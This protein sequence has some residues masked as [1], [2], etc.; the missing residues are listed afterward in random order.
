MRLMAAACVAAGSRRLAA[1][2]T[3][4]APGSRRSASALGVWLIIGALSETAFRVKASPHPGRE[5][6]RRLSNL[7]RSSFG[8]MMAHLGLGVL[9]IGIVATSAW[10]QERIL[11]MKAGETIN[12]AGYQLRFNDLASRP[13]PN[14][15]EL[16]AT[17]RG[18]TRRQPS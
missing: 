11:S 12:F 1:D 4:G 5:V 17:V 8:S 10:R 9:V 2:S 6:R 16:M 3:D 7:P 13:G 14:Y 15:Q 18:D